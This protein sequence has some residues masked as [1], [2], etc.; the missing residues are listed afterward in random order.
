MTTPTSPPHRQENKLLGLEAIRFVAALAV[1]VF[2]YD[3]FAYVADK[4]VHF[5]REHLPLYDVLGFFYDYGLCGVQVFWCLSGFIFF[6]K[7]KDAI[8]QQ[9]VTWKSFFIFRFSRLYPLHLATLLL[10]AVLQPI[11]FV[12][13]G[14][15]Y[16]YQ[17]ND[18]AQFIAQLFL[19]NNWTL[20][21][22]HSFNG[23]IWSI[24]VEVLVYLVFFLML[25]YISPSAWVNIAVVLLCVAAKLAG[26]SPPIL[27]CLVFFYA[28]GLAAITLRNFATTKYR[29]LTVG[30]A[31]AFVLMA[32]VAIGA[33]Q[34]YQYSHF[35]FVFLLTYVP[36]LLYV[37]AQNF[38]APAAVQRAV[39]A[40]GNMTYS[41]YLLHFPIQLTI[42]LY[43]DY[44]GQP[45]PYYSLAF[46]TVFMLAT[47]VASYC[48]YRLFEKPA[49]N[50]LRK[51]LKA[52]PGFRAVALDGDNRVALR[53]DN[54]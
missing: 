8:A 50:Y 45:I 1:L 20:E 30:L 34:A 36:A 53:T 51:T 21:R 18:I 47:L 23:P 31:L 33:T 26:I 7:Y 42:A 10:V 38:S 24:S 22:V 13:K 15:Y 40:A 3:H 46:F 35:A 19:A 54:G 16:V 32:P 39:E 48:V 37:T 2:H 12:Q 44:I 14:Y 29:R 17:N 43:F 52:K 27:D 5:V 49:Q 41:S 6:W 25:R 4:P 28:G 11:Y 9:V